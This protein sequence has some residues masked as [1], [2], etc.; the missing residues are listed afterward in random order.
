MTPS[1]QL[2]QSCSTS[3]V[4]QI[5]AQLQNAKALLQFLKALNFTDDVT[6]VFNE[7]GLKLTV[8]EA[9]TF[10][11]S[12]FL[13]KEIFRTFEFPEADGGGN[14]EDDDDDETAVSFKL[15]L[16]SLVQCLGMFG[17]SPG[18]AQPVLC[19]RYASGGEDP[20]QL[21]LE[22]S[23][24]VVEIRAQTR[25]PES[26]IDFE[27]A[28]GVIAAKVIMLSERLRDVLN[29]L[30][31]GSEWVEVR[32]C[33]KT[34][35]LHLSTSSTNGDMETEI[36]EVE[37]GVVAHFEAPNGEVR[38]RYRMSLF[39]HALRPLGISEKMSLRID[40][41]DVLCLQFMVRVEEHKSF[42]EYICLPEINDADD[43]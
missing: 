2:S 35:T 13:Q 42:L 9:R 6:L 34:R 23:G 11:A 14:E 24:V 26:M 21:W 29:D 1:S 12:A 36:P 10:Q 20:L 4:S 31:H 25:E 22:E 28:K 38:A 43:R 16:S 27:F 5:T 19:I 33:P 30:D 15:S 3:P 7:N 8:E 41:N 32:V 40:G 37:G 18:G 39:R 17:S